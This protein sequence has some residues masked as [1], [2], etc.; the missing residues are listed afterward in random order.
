MSL[1]Q[2]GGKRLSVPVSGG[3]TCNQVGAAIDA[4]AAGF[5]FGQ[6]L[7]YQVMPR[8]RQGELVAVLTDFEPTPA[9]LSL[10]YPHAR[11]LSARVRALID[12]IAED[13]GRSLVI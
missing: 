2:D 11:L 5:G 6:F 7:C 9:P 1:F 13:I 4:C 8:L 3:F 10:V 12:W